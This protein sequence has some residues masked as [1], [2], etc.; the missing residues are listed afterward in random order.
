MRHHLITAAFLVAASACYV[1]GIGVGVA[2]FVIAGAL[3]ESV[4]WFRLLRPRRR[5]H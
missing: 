3:L 1:A 5:V 4:F 2:G